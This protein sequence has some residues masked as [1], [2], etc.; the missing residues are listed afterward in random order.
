MAST[1]RSRKRTQKGLCIFRPECRRSRTG[2]LAPTRRYSYCRLLLMSQN[3]MTPFAIESEVQGASPGR[4]VCPR[5]GYY[6]PPPLNPR[7][8]AAW[9]P[10]RRVH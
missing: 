2:I 9:L 10:V 4:V 1:H 5:S 7:P 6:H 8:M 3:S